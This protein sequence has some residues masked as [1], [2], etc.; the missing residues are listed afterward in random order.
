MGILASFQ[1][2][3]IVR[4]PKNHDVFA[5]FSN[6]SGTGRIARFAK[7]K[8][9]AIDLGVTFQT[10]W[11]IVEDGS[12]SL[13]VAAGKSV[14]IFTQSGTSVGSFSVPGTAY[15][16]A[17]NFDLPLLYVMTFDNFDVEIFSYPDGKM[18]GTIKNGDRSKYAWPDGVAFWPPPK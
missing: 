4:D 3:G 18:V 15:R 1:A 2:L 13:L 12:G 5:T 7:G 10:P 9:P 11:G 8:P 6:K 17:F 16:M 14:D